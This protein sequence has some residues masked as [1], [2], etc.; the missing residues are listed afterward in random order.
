MAKRTVIK[1]MLMSMGMDEPYIDRAFKVYEKNY[2]QNC[3]VEVLTEIIVRLQYKDKYKANEG[4]EKKNV[5]LSPITKLKISQNI[6][7]KTGMFRFNLNA[8]TD[9][10]KKLKNIDKNKDVINVA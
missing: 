7:E 1:E 9:K 3:N 8:I 4:E 5:D 10:I 2:G 6:Q